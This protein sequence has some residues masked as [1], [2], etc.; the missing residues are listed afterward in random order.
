[1][2]SPLLG[3]ILDYSVVI[4]AERKRQTVEAFLTS[5]EQVF[6]QVEIA[7][8]QSRSLNSCMVSPAPTRLKC[9]SRDARSSMN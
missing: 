1:M 3:L 7:M 5:I 6:G 2:E 8:S 4:A 9:E